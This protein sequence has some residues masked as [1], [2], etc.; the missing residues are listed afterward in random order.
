MDVLNILEDGALNIVDGWLVIAELLKVNAELLFEEVLLV[1]DPKLMALLEAGKLLLNI[2]PVVLLLVINEDPLLVLL[3]LNI[4]EPVVVGLE[5]LKLNIFPL[6]LLLLFPL[7]RALVEVG[8]FPLLKLN[9]DPVPTLLE[10]LLFVEVDDKDQG[11][12]PLVPKLE[13]PLLLLAVLVIQLLLFP[14]PRVVEVIVGTDDV[15]GA[16]P[17]FW[18]FQ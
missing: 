18:A 6:M 14:P 4:L 11:L 13:L 7:A 17:F 16:I 10:V 2:E 15:V 5:L 3:L 1:V 8:L 12:L 9:N